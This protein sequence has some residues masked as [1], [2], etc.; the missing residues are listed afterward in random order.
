MSITRNSF[1]AAAAAAKEAIMKTRAERA[2]KKESRK[3]RRSLKK[4]ARKDKRAA[5]KKV[6]QGPGTRKE[7]KKLK[8]ATRAFHST[9]KDGKKGGFAA[10]GKFAGRKDS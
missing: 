6:R 4:T 2:E 8:G 7:K 10:F 9:D 5:L 1:G 3:E